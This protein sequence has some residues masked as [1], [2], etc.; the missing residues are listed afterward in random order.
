MHG[1][2]QTPFT[3]GSNWS[4]PTEHMFSLPQNLHRQDSF[5]PNPGHAEPAISPPPNMDFWLNLPVGEDKH[6]FLVKF[7]LEVARFLT[8]SFL[9][10]VFSEDEDC[11]A[12]D[13]GILGCLGSALIDEETPSCFCLP[14]KLERS[15]CFLF[16]YVSLWM[17]RC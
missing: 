1:N 2:Q 9:L 17:F 10:F 11:Q 13:P 12:G 16:I 3:Y 5:F 8:C 7:N 14:V 6:E 4:N 15:E